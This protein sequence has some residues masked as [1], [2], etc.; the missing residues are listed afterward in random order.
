M[1]AY[2]IVGI[3]VHPSCQAEAQALTSYLELEHCTWHVDADGVFTIYPIQGMEQLKEMLAE[4]Q[5]M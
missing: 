4:I 1:Q 3:N 2:E 5:A